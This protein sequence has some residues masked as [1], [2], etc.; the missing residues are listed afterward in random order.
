MSP[1][2]ATWSRPRTRSRMEFF[3]E[4]EECEAQGGIA[5]LQLSRRMEISLGEEMTILPT[6][7]EPCRTHS[8]LKG[9]NRL[10]GGSRPPNF[11]SQFRCSPNFLVCHIP[12]R[13]RDAVSQR[14]YAASRKGEEAAGMQQRLQRL[15]QPSQG[16]NPM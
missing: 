6:S 2:L 14:C 1:S 10:A 11:K 15:Q 4:R 12:S 16:G 7:E 3:S 13:Y 8:I 5:N 9:E